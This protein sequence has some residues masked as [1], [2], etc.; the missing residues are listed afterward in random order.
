VG[1][2]EEKLDGVDQALATL[3]KSEVEI[4]EVRTRFA[5]SGPVDLAAVDSELSALSDG[6]SIDTPVAPAPPVHAEAASEAPASEGLDW[7]QDNT[8]IEILDESD[9]VLLV[10]ENELDELE[11]VGE[12]DA[13]QSAP[14]A[15]P[16]AEGEEGDGFFKKLCGN[17]RSRPPQQE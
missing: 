5:S 1:K 8:E 7:E 6:V 13:I 15:I 12:E 3:G 16:D 4:S 17:R 11:K 10:D 14:T 9:F 2:S